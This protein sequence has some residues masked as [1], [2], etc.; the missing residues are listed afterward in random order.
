MSKTNVM[1][2]LSRSE[3]IVHPFPIRRIPNLQRKGSGKQEILMREEARRHET[4]MKSF[5]KSV[6]I[7]SS[8]AQ[9][10]ISR[11][12]DAV[13]AHCSSKF[14]VTHARLCQDRLLI[15]CLSEHG[16][17][18]GQLGRA[19]L[20]APVAGHRLQLHTSARDEHVTNTSHDIQERTCV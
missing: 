11:H 17:G 13:N 14:N 5:V 4:V 15:V 1:K 16:H 12:P 2:M 8:I 20:V 6:S 3:T 9:G 10:Q 19:L 7:I 18:S